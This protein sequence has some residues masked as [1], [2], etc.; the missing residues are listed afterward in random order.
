MRQGNEN[1]LIDMDTL[2]MGHPVFELAATYLAYV[3][4]SEIDS[5]CIP[6][7]MGISNELARRFYDATV[8][9][10]FETEYEGFLQELEK[11]L[12][13]LCFT[14]LIRRSIRRSSAD[15]KA[16]DHEVKT[17]AA[18]LEKL[19]PQVDKLYF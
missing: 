3:A 16:R 1:L 12:R 7:F 13:I 19:L 17:Y 11:K 6:K 14:R 10:Y 8:R 15:E 18:E 9:C 2:T 5:E 4:F